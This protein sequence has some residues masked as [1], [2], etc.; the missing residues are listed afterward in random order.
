MLKALSIDQARFIALLARNARVQRDAVLGH[1]AEKELDGE[2]AARGEHNPT[3][4]LGLDPLSTDALQPTA[5]LS[6]AVT[7]LP[8]ESRHELYTLMRI[9]QGHLAAEKWHR[10][11]SEAV[12]LGDAAV[13]AAITDDPDLHDHLAKGLYEMGLSS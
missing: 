4:A 2:K 3:A 7:S 8:V 6:D 13:V 10:G 9:G 5:A 12:A 11:L 1:V